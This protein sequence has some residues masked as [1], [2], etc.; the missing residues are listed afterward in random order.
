MLRT[1]LLPALTLITVLAL[2]SGA[3][4]AQD[5]TSGASPV[6]GATMAAVDTR[7]AQLEELM[8]PTLAGLPLDDNLQL[9]TGEELISVMQ[10]QESDLLLTLLDE[11]DKTPADYAAGATW[12]PLAD[13]D[14]VVVQAH[15]IAGI[16][17]GRTIEA[18]LQ[19]LA[20][21][22][23]QPAT[24]EGLIGGR[25][26]RLLANEAMPDMPLLYLFPVDDVI[27]MV[28]AADEAIVEEA[29]AA[30][31]AEGGETADMPA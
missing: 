2:P 22:L 23:E 27:W 29:M 24:S 3:A 12:L 14:I 21:G 31:G 15:R 1:R 28:V 16:D 8:P 7:L 17:A 20:L 19:I 10:P 6:P 4:T 11:H 25:P 30:V 9:A 13:G 5:E 26:V 18:W